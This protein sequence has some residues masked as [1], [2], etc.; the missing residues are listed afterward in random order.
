MALRCKGAGRELSR[1]FIR[2]RDIDRLRL[3]P[4][5]A[6]S[7]LRRSRRAPRLS[8]EEVFEVSAA[9]SSVVSLRPRR[10]ILTLRPP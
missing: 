3:T 9:E 6:E 2:E 7:P 10:G 5:E 4:N 8:E 1:P